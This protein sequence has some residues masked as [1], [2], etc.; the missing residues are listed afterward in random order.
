MIKLKMRPLGC[1]YNL[2]GVLTRTGHLAHK[3]EDVQ[4]Q[5]KDH[6]PRPCEDAAKAAIGRPRTEVSEETKPAVT[7]IWDFQP[8]EL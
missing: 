1:P 2:T 7:L 5:R 3:S 4:S 8:P 6:I